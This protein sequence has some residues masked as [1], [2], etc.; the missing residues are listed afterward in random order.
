MK[1]F[2]QPRF[3]TGQNEVIQE[4]SALFSSMFVQFC[5]ENSA[6]QTINFANFQVSTI[7]QSS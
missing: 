4:L 1:L 2:E 5:T 6:E 7:D 3:G